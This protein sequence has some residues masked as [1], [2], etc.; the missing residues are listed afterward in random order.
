MVDQLVQAPTLSGSI[1]LD[2]DSKNSLQRLMVLVVA[3]Q[4]RG[5]VL[6]LRILRSSTN[7]LQT[8]RVVSTCEHIPIEQSASPSAE[9][10]KNYELRYEDY[11]MTF[12]D[13]G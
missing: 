11:V 5:A 6:K 1:L 8:C 12:D 2:P 9:R 4:L 7:T 10:R 3:P 13:N